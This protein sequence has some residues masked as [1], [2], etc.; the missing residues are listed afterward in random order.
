MTSGASLPLRQ[1]PSKR[2]DGGPVERDADCVVVVLFAPGLNGS[3]DSGGD[4][5]GQS[6]ATLKVFS[7]NNLES[8]S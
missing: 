6:P 8:L 2:S 1:R 3:T 5:S 7:P 4:A